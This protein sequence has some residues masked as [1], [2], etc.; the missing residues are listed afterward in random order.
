MA[1][2]TMGG[3]FEVS[4]VG[5]F[6]FRLREIGSR[7]VAVEGLLLLGFLLTCSFLVR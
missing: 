7:T 1:G 5:Q 4:R 3:S 2:L 6:R